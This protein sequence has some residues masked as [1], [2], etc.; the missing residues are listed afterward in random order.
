MIE[1]GKPSPSLLEYRIRIA[2]RSERL[3][4]RR[5][6]ELVGKVDQGLAL[7]ADHQGPHV[8]GNE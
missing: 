4:Q 2:D 1:F 3:A 6:H 8:T 5:Q 7:D